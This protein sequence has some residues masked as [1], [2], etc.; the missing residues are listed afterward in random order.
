MGEFFD[1]WMND[2]ISYWAATTPID[3]YGKPTFAAPVVI[4]G[5]WEDK[6]ELITDRRGREIR[7]RARVWFLQDVEIGDYVMLGSFS[8]GDT[9]PTVVDG[10]Y[11]IKDFRTVR[12]MDGDETERIG[13]LA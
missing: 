4:S 11:E 6:V 8:S 7:A 10:A 9:D 1:E 2:S 13:F 3:T 12:S 5:R